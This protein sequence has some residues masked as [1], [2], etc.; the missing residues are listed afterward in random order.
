MRV[1]LL[2]DGLYPFV[3]GGMQKHSYSLTKYLGKNA[4]YVDVY[5][6]YLGDHQKYLQLKNEYFNEIDSKYV[7]LIHVDYPKS[8]KFP[9]HYLAEQYN[10]SKNVY[11]ILSKN[12]DYDFVYIQGFSGWYSL[13]H[14]SEFK[15]PFGINFHGYEMFQKAPDTSSWL[16]MQLL[17]YPVKYNIKKSDVVYSFGEVI[18]SIL[19]DKI[20]LKQNKINELSN[21]IEEDWL[22]DTVK[23]KVDSLKF[24][25]VGRYERRKGIQE[26]TQVIKELDCLDNVEFH[27]IGPI[28]E[29]QKIAGRHVIYYG[30]INDEEELKRIL[31]SCD[32]LVCPSYSEGMPTVILEAMA[33]G[34]AII[35]TDVGA[36]RKLVTESNGWLIGKNIKSG[37]KNTIK[38]VLETDN[39]R[40]SDMK[41]TSLRKVKNEFLWDYIIKQ[42]ITTINMNLKNYKYLA[43]NY[44]T[45]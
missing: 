2:T 15:S 22:T 17:K 11:D 26:L 21:G 41:Q 24:V 19:L 36:I 4:I 16:K 35:A 5:H 25:F 45:K 27:F 40:L 44:Q 30:L 23:K 39:D 20:K 31:R 38:K 10:Y 34:L 8:Q 42:L 12:G 6:F 18:S 28:P 14:K 33:S 13:K 43:N 32:V 3:I 1:A 7:K 29:N 9:G 37:L